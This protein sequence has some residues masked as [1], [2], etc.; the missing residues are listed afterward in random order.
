MS[1]IDYIKRIT[2][3]YKIKNLNYLNNDQ[4]LINMLAFTERMGSICKTL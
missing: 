2:F 3:K 4:N 1:K